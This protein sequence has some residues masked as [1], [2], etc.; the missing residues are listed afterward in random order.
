M[1]C[2]ADAQEGEGE[3]GVC[4]DAFEEGAEIV[5]LFSRDNRGTTFAA[6][7]ALSTADARG[8]SNGCPAG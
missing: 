2:F 4:R 7:T 6:G 8:S 3:L 1:V 5:S